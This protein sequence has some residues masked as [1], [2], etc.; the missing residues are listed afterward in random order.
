MEAFGG[1]KIIVLYGN[2][3]HPNLSKIT[4]TRG[5]FNAG[6]KNCIELILNPEQKKEMDKTGNA[7]LFI[8]HQVG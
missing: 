8:L 3:C 4:E 1:K 2:I 5:V 6:T 7:M